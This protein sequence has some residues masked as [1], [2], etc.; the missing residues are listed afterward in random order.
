VDCGQVDMIDMSL[1]D[2]NKEPVEDA[3]HG[4]RLVEVF[5]ELP[6]GDVRLG[7]AGRI[8]TPADVQR[9]LDDG[10]DLAVLGRVGILHHDFPQLAA[11]PQWVPR[12]APVPADV[13]AAEGVSPVFVEYLRSTFRFVADQS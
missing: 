8:H 11:D 12:Q 5:A 3:H 1:W 6:R 13:L 4:R 2:V 7:A 10:L 9:A